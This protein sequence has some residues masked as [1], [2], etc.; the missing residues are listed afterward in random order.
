LDFQ[1]SEVRKARGAEGQND[2]CDGDSESELDAPRKLR[3]LQSSYR[4]FRPERA[5]LKMPSCEV[6]LRQTPNRVDDFHLSPRSID[7]D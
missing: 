2:W 7:P 5:S 3:S 4:I 1:T 6:R